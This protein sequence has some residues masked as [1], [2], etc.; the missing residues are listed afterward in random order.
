MQLVGFFDFRGYEE[1]KSKDGTKT[2]RFG[3]FE[4]ADDVSERISFLLTGQAYDIVPTL[5]RGTMVVVDVTYSQY[6]NS[7]KATQITPSVGDDVPAEGAMT[8]AGPQ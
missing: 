8:W 1:R 6:Y 5:E 3:Y 4:P 7:F 2:L